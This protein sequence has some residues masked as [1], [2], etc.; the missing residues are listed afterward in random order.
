MKVPMH[1][2]TIW[3]YT[4]MYYIIRQNYV[5]LK[6]FLKIRNWSYMYETDIILLYIVSS[7]SMIILKSIK[8]YKIEFKHM[9]DLLFM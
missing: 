7:I 1:I 2:I 8:K 3:V 5:I 6:K 9:F 4:V